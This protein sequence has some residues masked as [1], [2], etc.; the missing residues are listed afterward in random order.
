MSLNERELRLR[1]DE[2]V[3]RIRSALDKCPFLD[4]LDLI[5]EPEVEAAGV[6]AAEANRWLLDALDC[7][8]ELERLRGASQEAALLVATSRT[9]LGVVREVLTALTAAIDCRRAA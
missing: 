1:L 4:E 8:D 2:D 9:A 6:L 3:R 7:T 5:D